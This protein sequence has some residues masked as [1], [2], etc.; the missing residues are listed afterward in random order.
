MAQRRIC[1]LATALLAFAAVTPDIGHT[2]EHNAS[3]P[4]GWADDV[5]AI[6]SLVAYSRGESDLRTAVTRYVEDRA[7]IQRRYP[8]QFSPVRIERLRKFHE[9]WRQRLGE[10]DFDSL[11]HEGRIDYILLRNRI[12]HDLEG[13]RLSERNS[14]ELSQLVPF[15]DE[16]RL[17]EESR[18]DKKR[19]DARKA[20]TTLTEIA[21]QSRQLAASFGAGGREGAVA[22]KQPRA[23]KDVALRASEQLTHLLEILTEWH[24]FYDGYDPEFTWWME[25]PFAGAKSDIAAYAAALEKHVVG[26]EANTAP[27]VG[28]PVLA[29]GLQA[30]LDVEMIPYTA[31]ELISIGEEEFKWIEDQMVSVS[32]E[33]GFGD[34]WKAAL[35]HTKNLAPPPGEIP[36]VLY[37]IAEYSENFIEDLDIIDLPPLSREIWRFTMQTPE[38]QLIN[39]FFSGGE[40]THLSYPTNSMEHEQKMMSMRGNT[41]HFNFPTVQH[42]LVPGHHLQSF[43]YSRFNSHRAELNRTPF[44]MEGWALYWEF[45]LWDEDFSRNNPDKIGMLFWRMHRAAR[46]IFSLNYQL[47]SWSAQQCVDFLVDRVGHERA[48]AEAEVRRSARAEPL[49]QAAYMLGALQIRALHR[50]LVQSGDLSQQDFHNAFLIGGPMPI[51]MVRARLTG[52][53]LSRDYESSWRF[54][55]SPRR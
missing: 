12:D 11:N 53:G 19:V 33:M 32:N 14:A 17:L 30:D 23:S 8:V 22:T 38:R 26:A 48:N 42:E 20:A 5:P 54:Y 52:Q 6:S 36:W 39:P 4:Q 41:P 46:I 35:E 21:K 49:Y 44:W 16:I 45:T 31:K 13:L 3:L 27:I 40:V 24:G 55:E 25:K 9:S 37:D 18:L 28:A 1:L 50:E 51:E 43:M 7:A 15:R 47:G 29:E 10:V 2:Q 34:D